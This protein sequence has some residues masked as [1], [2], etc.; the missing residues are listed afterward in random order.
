MSFATPFHISNG[1]LLDKDYKPFLLHPKRFHLTD[2]RN[3]AELFLVSCKKEKINLIHLELTESLLAENNGA[4]KNGASL[5]LLDDVMEYCYQSGIYLVI[6]PITERLRIPDGKAEHAIR[7]DEPIFAER[8]FDSLFRHVNK[9]SGK[10]FFEYENLAG[11]EFLLAL[12]SF[13]V[14]RLNTY[15][16]HIGCFVQHFFC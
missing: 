16:H 11:I 12:E 1:I 2:D 10:M 4:L 6:T 14:T 3:S 13:T 9:N 7:V 5:E 15:I 8:F